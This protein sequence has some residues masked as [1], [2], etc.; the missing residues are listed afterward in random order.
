MFIPVRLSHVIQVAEEEKNTRMVI[1]KG[2]EEDVLRCFLLATLVAPQFTPVTHSLGRSFELAK[3]VIKELIVVILGEDFSLKMLKLCHRH[4]QWI[5]Q[6]CTERLPEM[7]ICHC[8]PSCRDC[9]KENVDG[10]TVD[11]MNNRVC[12]K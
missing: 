10:R 7:K 8:P 2:R 5:A 9:R 1:R 3:L 11:C 12:K 4:K 6:D